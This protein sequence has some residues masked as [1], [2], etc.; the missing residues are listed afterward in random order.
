MNNFERLQIN[1]W[2]QFENIDISFHPSVTILTGANGSGKTTILLMLARHNGWQQPTLATPKLD[3]FSN[4][5]KYFSNFLG[6]I[7]PKQPSPSPGVFANSLNINHYHVPQTPSHKIGVLKYTNG[8]E[9]TILVP[10]AGSPQYQLQISNQQQA[11]IFYIPSHRQPFSYKRISQLS[12]SRKERQ[13]AFTEVQSSYQQRHAGGYGT[14]PTSYIMKNALL[15]WVVNGYG[16]QNGN[17]VVM[18]SDQSQISNFEGFRD[19]LRKVLPETLGF[20]DLEIRDYE[21]VFVCN[22]GKD[23]F[24]LET[25]SGG[26]SALIDIAW[27]VYMFDTDKNQS[28]AVIIDEIENHLHPS[29]QRTLLPKL[30]AAFPHVRFIVST[31]SPLVVTSVENCYVY[32][33]GYTEKKKI[34][35]HLLDFKSEVKNAVDVLDEVLGVSTTIPEWAEERLDAILK[36]YERREINPQSLSELRRE[37]ESAGLGRLFPQAL[38]YIAEKNQ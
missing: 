22:G 10:D 20:E 7:L 37:I 34:K 12:T 35:S 36:G 4:S 2:Q 17:K 29:M 8:I 26:V 6:K 21:L 32:A 38:T 3:A 18:P 15:G 31:H 1:S 30:V 11:R 14:E 24:L 9:A 19:V 23:E 5:L 33:L 13:E 28:F 16:V 25:A 27:Q